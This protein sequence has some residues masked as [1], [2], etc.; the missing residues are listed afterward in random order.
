M[1]KKVLAGTLCVMAIGTASAAPCETVPI[2]RQV[3]IAA[4]IR[5]TV[6]TYFAHWDPEREEAFARA[7][8]DY[9]AKVAP[10]RCRR[11]VSLDSM[12]VVASLRNGHTKFEDGQLWAT[13]VGRTGLAV[14]HVGGA[15]RVIN[16]QRRQV[17]P[18][19]EIVAVDGQPIEAF[20]QRHRDRI[21]A[22]SEQARRDKLFNM[23]I[24][25]PEQFTLRFA[26]ATEATVRRA[27]KPQF[28]RDPPVPELPEGVK[29]HVIYSFSDPAFEEKALSFITDNRESPAIILDVRGNS[30]GT[31][32]SRLMAALIERPYVSWG[33]MSA[34]S[35][36]LLKAYGEMY[37]PATRD[38]DPGFSGFAEGMN[39]WFA[40]PLLYAPG[41]RVMPE[42]PVFTHPLYVLVDR[43]C[44]SACEDFVYALKAS[45]RAVIVGEATNGSSGQTHVVD[46]GD[47]M[48]L[49]VGAKRMVMADGSPFEGRGI[50]PDVAVEVSLED[51]RL[52]RDVALEA[53]LQRLAR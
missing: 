6:T 14:D 27:D 38:E 7:W 51:V 17:T 30:G 4:S 34:L 32:P 2:A 16:S 53:V 43:Q 40:R 52:N 48:E 9:I 41:K 29:L 12:T 44:G 50:A 1:L 42:T 18:G 20:Y 31:T 3:E 33:E 8:K 49:R 5:E 24:L 46:L 13:S 39:A 26:D 36:G 21:S 47:G 45:G 35:V 11:D 37:D 15:W 25:F 22:S 19:K 23:A 10:G 28:W